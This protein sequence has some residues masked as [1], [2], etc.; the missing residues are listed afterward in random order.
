MKVELEWRKIL[1]DGIATSL[2]TDSN[3]IFAIGILPM[4][5]IKDM[6]PFITGWYGGISFNI[7]SQT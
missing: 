1:W 3:D 2:I 4:S 7:L 6:Y 5:P